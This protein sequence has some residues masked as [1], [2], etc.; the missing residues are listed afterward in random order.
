[1]AKISREKFKVYSGVFD[2][3]TLSTLEELKRKKYYDKLGKPIKTGKEADIYLAY[4]KEKKLAIKIYR[5]TNSN[6]KKI[7]QYI[8][9]DY[10]FKTQKGS[11][12]TIILEWTKKE[13]R[14]LQICNKTNIS[15][16]KVHKFLNN[17]IIMDYINGKMLKDEFIEN[18]K[19]LFQEILRQI[20]SMLTKA[21]LIHA[22]LSAFNILIK[23]QSPVIIDL[24]QAI[25]FK[26]GRDFAESEKIFKRDI[27]T[28]TNHFNKKYNLELNTEKIE[29]NLKEEIFKVVK[30]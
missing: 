17:C 10:R 28:I 1:M 12:R 4:K 18:P 7:S 22:D 26:S 15:T 9:R 25:S 13:F 2:N 29:K 24:G 14:N 16:P 3:Y 27:K 5:M 21:R 30:V 6:F 11:L 20:T 8:Q 19:N 23:D